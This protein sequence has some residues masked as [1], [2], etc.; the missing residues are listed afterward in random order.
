MQPLIGITGN[1]TLLSRPGDVSAF[2]I[3]YSPRSIST[4]VQH[5][6]GT[7]LI[8]PMT[9]PED[10]AQYISAV[11]GL[12]LAGGQDISP[13]FYGEEPQK[14][15][16]AVSPERDR[17]E[18]ALIKE[19][20]QQKKA[21]LGICRGM[22]LV[23]VALG[24]TLYQDIKH[25]SRFTVQ[26][27]QK[28]Q[29]HFATHTVFVSEDS[30]LGRLIPDKSLVNSFHHQAIRDLAEPLHATARSKD[31]V[32]E[33]VEAMDDNYS[34]VGVQWHPELTFETDH[35]SLALFQDLVERT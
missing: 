20:I 7:P 25:D 3:N 27:D 18:L 30:Y 24:G 28:S 4:A 35:P 32:I 11:D 1:T 34:I 23:N 5:A 6:G 33:A 19:A 29:P 16:G 12:V 2:E 15:I 26:H 17:I 8:I 13:L 31:E 21:I 22:Q 14:V 9:Q 10:A